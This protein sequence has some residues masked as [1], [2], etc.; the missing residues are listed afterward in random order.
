MKDLIKFL[1]V[2][3]LGGLIIGGNDALIAA[4]I[5]TIAA[6]LIHLVMEKDKME[7]VMSAAMDGAKDA[8]L[9]AFVLMLA[10]ALAAIFMSTGTGAAAISLFLKL[11][12]NGKM[13]AVVA[14]LAACVISVATGTSWG[15]VAC[16]LPIFMWLCDIVNGNPALTFAAIVGGGAFGDNIGLISDTTILSSGVQ[17]VKTVDRVAC[18]VVWSIACIALS[19]VCFITVSYSMGLGSETG[20]VKEI[21][22]NITPETMAVL[23]E[24]RPAVITLLQQVQQGVSPLML[25]PVVLIIAMAVMKIDTIICLTSGIALSSVMGLMFGYVGSVHEIFDL[26]YSGIAD[27]G[28]WPVVLI[29]WVSAF[30]AVMRSMNAFEAVAKFLLHISGKVRTLICWNGLLCLIG[31]MA[32]SEDLS[33]IS[34]IGPVIKGIVEDNVDGSEEDLYKLKMRNALF[35]DAVGVHAGTL[36]PWHATCVYYLGLV[37]AVYPLY[38]FAVKD[39]FLNFMSIISLL[40]LFALTFTGLDRFLPGMRMPAEPAV[41]LKKS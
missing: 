34:A 20:N 19:A 17:G 12:V 41:R 15:T 1:P 4:P 18:Q 38:Q 21:F 11:G 32:L 9:P 13:V 16:C 8:V 24:K 25:I 28:A 31:N 14:F 27:A 2:V 30:G 7:D 26:V 22:E 29:L 6:I 39:L 10:Y 23:E 36:I 33:T 5:A 35:N 40:S 3:I 37:T